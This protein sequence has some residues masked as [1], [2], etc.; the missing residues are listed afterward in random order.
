MTILHDAISHL[1][2]RNISLAFITFIL[3][4]VVAQIVYYRFFHPLRKFPG[5]FWPSVTRLWIGW[6]CWRQTE[7][8]TIY[9]LHEKY[10]VFPAPSKKSLG[11]VKSE[12]NNY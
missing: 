3:Y 5:P 1:S 9:R 11:M 12:L 7:L 10:G 6:H 4:K 2:F 8:E